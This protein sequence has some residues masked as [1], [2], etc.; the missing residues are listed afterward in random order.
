MKAYLKT[1]PELA[2]SYRCAV[3]FRTYERIGQA[4][5][6]VYQTMLP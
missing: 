6:R 5:G 4:L 1:T 3:K 2:N